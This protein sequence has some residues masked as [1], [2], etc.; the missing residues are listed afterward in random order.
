MMHRRRSRVWLVGIAVLTLVASLVVSLV[1]SVGAA[2]QPRNSALR[3]VRRVGPISAIATQR[4]AASSNRVG[5]GADARFYRQHHIEPQEPE[6]GEAIRRGEIPAPRATRHLRVAGSKGPGVVASWE[7]LNHFDSRYSGNGNQFSGEPP[8]QGLCANNRRVFETVNSVVQVYS[9]RGNPLI[10]GDPYYPGTAPV[11]LTISQFL[12][13]SPEIVRTDPPTY[14]RFLSDPSCKWDPSV[15]RWFVTSLYLGQD[16]ETG[17]FNGGGGIYIAVSTSAN[18]LGTW[19]VYDLRTQ[20]NGKGGTPNHH[21]SG[22]YC[23]SDY[24]QLG[25]NADGVFISANEFDLLGEGEFKGA[26]LWAI[27]KADLVA[28]RP[29]PTMQYFPKIKS[30]AVDFKAYTLQ[31]VDAQPRDFV[32]AHGGTMYFGMSQ[33]PLVNGAA[34]GVSLWRLTNTST[35]DTASP[36]LAL[37]ETDVRTHAYAFPVFSLQRPGPTP[38]LR[39][40]ND[41]KCIGVDYPHQISPLPI[42]SGSG[43]VYGAWLRHGVVYLTTHSALRGPGGARWNARNGSWKPINMH[44][45]VAFVA[46]RP[47]TTSFNVARV[48][49]GVVDVPGENL[50]FP[51]VALNAAGEGV[52][53]ATLV[54][55]DIY[56]SQAYIPFTARAETGAVHVSG[57]GVGPNDGFTGTGDGGFDPRWGDYGAASVSPDGTIWL[58]NEYIAQRCTFPEFIADPTCGYT[59]TFYANW[60]TRI[61]A[62][63]P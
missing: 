50:L 1:G 33:S 57:R 6:G 31:P 32:S 47:S 12:G 7:G 29:A 45:G 5:G 54:G 16:R 44:N 26:E 55:L 25:V 8:D 21:C 41:V 17:A 60:S 30:P 42:G 22:G 40:E 3:L 36:N 9:P 49:Q 56:P 46:L 59:R 11:G 62:Y 19:N 61:T 38:L 39:C 51:E 43:K 27:S 14:G 52:I 10:S 23:F 34:H 4:T 15:N 48:S 53:G 28:G 24:P 13:I 35:L 20:N 2:A 58:G 18:P 63:N 37:T